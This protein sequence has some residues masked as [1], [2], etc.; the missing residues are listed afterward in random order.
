MMKD[1]FKT[2]IALL[3]FSSAFFIGLYLGKEK[4]KAKIPKFQEDYNLNSEEF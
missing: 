2:L 4:E 1:I 3:C